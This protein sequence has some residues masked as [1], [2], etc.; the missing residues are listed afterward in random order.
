MA[1]SLFSDH[2]KKELAQAASRGERDV[3]QAEIDAIDRKLKVAQAKA[4]AEQALPVPP[5]PRINA[6]DDAGRPFATIEVSLK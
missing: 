5:L 4:Q 2:E 6:V 1:T 3:I